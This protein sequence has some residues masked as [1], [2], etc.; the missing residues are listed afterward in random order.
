MPIATHPATIRHAIGTRA[1]VLNA[2]QAAGH[3]IPEETLATTT[4]ILSATTQPVTMITAIASH[5]VTGHA[6]G[7]GLAT[8]NAMRLTTATSQP[9]GTTAAIAINCFYW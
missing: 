7:N 3:P 5:G 4:V 8:G 2:L 9:V 1:G 6:N